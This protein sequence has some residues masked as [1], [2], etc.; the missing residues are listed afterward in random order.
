[1]QVLLLEDV[2]NLGQA[3]DIA[4]TSEGYARNFL[5]PQGKAALATKQVKT[6]K[7]AK[8]AAAKK[9]VEEEL[10]LQQEIASKL[11]NTELIV[12]GKPKEGDVLYGSL[13][14]KEVAAL[15][16]SQSGINITPRNITGAFPFKRL[17]SYLITVQL[18]QGVEFQMSV[19]VE[20]YEQA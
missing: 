9:M 13:T 15:L 3:G 1:M 5:F 19:V 17:G 7:E 18:A 4:E 10:A 12:T 20:P 14:I 6:T 8:D 16:S 11:E 2:K